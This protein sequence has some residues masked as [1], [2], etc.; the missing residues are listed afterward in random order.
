MKK[1]LT[2]LCIVII[3]VCIASDIGY[4]W[5]RQNAD[6]HPTINTIKMSTLNN[7]KVETYIFDMSY[8]ANKDNLGVEMFELKLNCYTGINKDK[9]YSYGVQILNPK[10]ITYEYVEYSNSI[11]FFS[12]NHYFKY[13]FDMSKSNV[14]YFNSDNDVSYSASSSL[15]ENEYP[16]VVD[17]GNKLYAF[18]FDKRTYITGGS[19]LFWGY[20]DYMDSTFEYFLYKMYESLS[21]LSSGEG[22]YDSLNVNLNDVF[23][24]YSYND[25]T[26][27]FDVQTEYGYSPIYMG[28]KIKYVNRGAKVHSDS[29]FNKINS[30]FK[31]GLYYE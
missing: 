30:S 22:I 16:Y 20:V 7:A 3:L 19:G 5:I 24:L 10:N 9:I 26:K 8:Y 11:N 23:V 31:G 14:S 2:C 4:V 13:N 12:T 25:I 17:I 6:K 28:V 29:M 27:K 15:N 18:N 1:F 21:T